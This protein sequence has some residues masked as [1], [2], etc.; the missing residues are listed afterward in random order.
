MEIQNL[1]KED[2]SL[3]L[4]EFGQVSTKKLIEIISEI[5]NGIL[6]D[7]G[8]YYGCSSKIMISNSSNN[9]NKIFGI[10]PIP[11]YRTNNSNY[12]YIQDD[13]VL[14]G[15][16]WD[17]GKVDLVFFDSVHAKEQVLCELYYWWE[18]IKEGGYAIFH[19]TSWDGYIHPEGHSCAGK[20]TG[21]TGLG[22]DS[23]GGIEWETPDKAVEDFFKIKI[24]T[25]NRN[26]NNDCF[27]LIY[28]DN[29]IKVEANYARLGMTV[30]TKKN[31]FDYKQNVKNWDNIFQ[32]R[33]K[34]LSFFKK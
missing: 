13:S 31:N 14:V 11:F 18:L 5:K 29:N 3:I 8:V 1:S 20:K 9:N 23:Y 16:N 15:S 6:I 33:E 26:I 12:T 34:L 22:Y 21:N 28:E 32:K 2:A 25:E 17:K 10:D 4:T 19:D 30:I 27:L 24:N 7:I